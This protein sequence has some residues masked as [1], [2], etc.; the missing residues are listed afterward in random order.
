MD[1]PLDRGRQS[2]CHRFAHDVGSLLIDKTATPETPAAA[3][4]FS[5]GRYVRS[6]HYIMV[7]ILFIVL[8]VFVAV[9][10]TLRPPTSGF[11]SVSN[12]L[13]LQVSAPG[14]RTMTERLVLRADGGARLIV[15]SVQNP[16]GPTTLWINH[17]AGE[18]VCTPKQTVSVTYGDEMHVHPIPAF[19]VKFL[20]QQT[21]TGVP[22]PNGP[23]G[24]VTSIEVDSVGPGVDVYICFRRAAPVRFVGAYLSAQFAPISLVNAHLQ[25]VR[26]VLILK[27]ANTADFSIQSP[28][29]PL[30]TDATSWFWAQPATAQRIHLS[31]INV[32]TSQYENHQAFL[33]GIALGIAGG[34]LITILQELVAPFSRRKDERT[35]G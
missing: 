5:F 13:T 27:G 6:L 17:W 26:S 1:C 19:K 24:P 35:G 4:G 14:V 33:S 29:S 12:N 3:P 10:W 34:A 28:V 7:S 32:T 15:Q 2:V 8:V 22:I 30:S 25:N 21:A 18:R 9:G 16:K 11:P 23:A 20:R 31:A